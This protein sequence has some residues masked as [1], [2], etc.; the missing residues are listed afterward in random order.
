MRGVAVGSVQ[1]ILLVNE[2]SPRLGK[3]RMTDE[4]YFRTTLNVLDKNKLRRCQ[5]EHRH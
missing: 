3:A 4:A 2:R 1:A 5:D